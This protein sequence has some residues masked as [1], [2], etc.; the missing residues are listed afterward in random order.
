MGAVRIRA[1]FHGG[2]GG[3]VPC[4]P[5]RRQKKAAKATTATM[6]TITPATIRTVFSP[7]GSKGFCGGLAEIVMLPRTFVSSLDRYMNVPTRYAV[8]FHLSSTTGFRPK[9]GELTFVSFA[10]TAELL[11]KSM[12]QL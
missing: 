11:L 10:L 5:M 9:F 3:G 1:R 8:K 6:I 4:L 7:P 12:N 2:G